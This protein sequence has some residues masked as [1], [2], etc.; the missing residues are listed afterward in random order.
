MLKGLDIIDEKLYSSKLLVIES[1]ENI[2]SIVLTM[3]MKEARQCSVL[4]KV[5]YN[6]SRLAMMHPIDVRV[7]CI[8]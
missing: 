5:G 6:Q 3:R 4:C 7:G 8:R 1:E 2:F